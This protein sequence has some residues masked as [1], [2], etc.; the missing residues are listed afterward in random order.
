MSDARLPAIPDIHGHAKGE[1]KPFADERPIPYSARLIFLWF[2][3]AAQRRSPRFVMVSD[4]INYLTFEDPAAVSLV[5]RALKLALA[6]DLHGA[7]ETANVDMHHAQVVSEAMR[8]GMRFSIGAEVDNDPRSRPDAQNVV[9]AIKP[10]GLIRSIHFLP[11]KHPETGEEWMWPFDNPEFIEYYAKVG[12]EEVWQ[13][14][15]DLL[16]DAVNNLPGDILGHLHVP[17]KFGHWPE[18]H[19]LEAHEDRILDACMARGMGIEINTR[20]FYRN[21]DPAV[22]QL[23][24]DLYRRL[25]KKCLDR[26]LPIAIGSDAHSPKDQGRGI[27]RILPL[28]DE[29]D[30]NE[31]VFPVNGVLARV[32]LRADRPIRSR[33]SVVSQPA[34]QAIP[35]E[36]EAGAGPPELDSHAEAAPAAKAPVPAQPA[37]IETVS[38]REETLPEENSSDEGVDVHAPAK[39]SGAKKASGSKKA[40]GEKA[41]AKKA[42]AKTDGT[43]PAAKKAAAT[44]TTASA[45]KPAEKKTAE[46]KKAPAEKKPAPKKKPA[47]ESD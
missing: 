31:I 33:P 43:K 34:R 13:I 11:I 17:G 8:A 28:L 26:D 37:H 45:K 2:Y 10:D 1:H 20:V 18:L 46:K 7:S 25:L 9:D 38:A 12:T 22:H 41:P 35:L 19:I 5:R 6:G 42:D 3:H 39:G 24:L 27:D 47:K 36:P 15:T 16:V 40:A 29:L 21:N 4:H 14:Y 44:K 23:Y 32:V 30:I